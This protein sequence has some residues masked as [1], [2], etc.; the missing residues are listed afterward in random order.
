V[1]KG[2]G[3]TCIALKELF[4]GV[5]N[6]VEIFTYENHFDITYRGYIH[7]QFKGAEKG[8]YV[9]PGAFQV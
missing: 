2:I 1:K 6:L 7:L 9:T 3:F 8:S 4:P 5:R